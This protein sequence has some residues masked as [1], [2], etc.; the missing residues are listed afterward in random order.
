MPSSSSALNTWLNLGAKKL[1]VTSMCANIK[2][3]AFPENVLVTVALK[4][5]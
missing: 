2:K 4:Q 3:I 1:L 5:G